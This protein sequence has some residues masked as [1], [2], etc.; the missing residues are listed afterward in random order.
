MTTFQSLVTN[1]VSVQESADKKTG[2]AWL[3]IGKDGYAA[4]ER[5]RNYSSAKEN[6]ENRDRLKAACV[7]GMPA[8]LRKLIETDPAMLDEVKKD[9][10]RAALQR[11]TGT[12]VTRVIKYLVQEEM[13]ATG[14]KLDLKTG[15]PIEEATET[16]EGKSGSKTVLAG[17]KLPE[18]PSHEQL[19]AMVAYILNAVREDDGKLFEGKKV[20]IGKGCTALLSASNY[21]SFAAE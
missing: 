3:T 6:K 1:A 20:D 17:L 15:L 18:K 13:R 10:R 16:E 21:L 14:S 12:Y 11:A 19:S 2:N 7:A 5:G 8:D 9:A 4:G